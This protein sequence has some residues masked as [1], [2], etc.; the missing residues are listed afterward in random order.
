MEEHYFPKYLNALPQILWWELDELAFL[1][2]ATGIGIMAN[3]Q[4]IGAGVGFLLMKLY[5]NLKKKKQPGYLK[6]FLYKYGL[7]GVK[8]KYPEFWIKE[9]M[10]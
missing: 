7:F 9:L 8:G 4:L 10:T 2:T 6:H 3:A 5:A 1:A